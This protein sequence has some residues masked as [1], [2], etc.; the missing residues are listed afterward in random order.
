G[1]V[2]HGARV[3]TIDKVFFLS[4]APRLGTMLAPTKML[5]M[6]DG[7]KVQTY[8]RW[9]GE[10]EIEGICIRGV[11]EIF[12]SCGGWKVLFGKPLQAAIGAVHNVKDDIVVITAGGRTA[13][14]V[15]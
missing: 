11:F 9:I 10:V 2:R 13:T 6:A 3:G 1:V 8:G 5:R 15:N 4:K 12:D 7:T 14:L